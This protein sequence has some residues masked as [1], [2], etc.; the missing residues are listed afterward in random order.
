M[1][2]GNRLRHFRFEH[3]YT[4]ETAAHLLGVSFSA[5]EK[6]ESD[7]RRPTPEKILRLA[8]LYGVD[9]SILVGETL[10]VKEEK[11]QLI[12]L[13]LQYREMLAVLDSLDEPIRTE[14]VQRIKSLKLTSP[15]EDAGNPNLP[16][17]SSASSHRRKKLS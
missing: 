10:T 12:A 2:L 6:W 17:A 1:T 7:K 16:F 15:L 14:I 4:R 5:L 13:A 11:S 8:R 9:V 3:G